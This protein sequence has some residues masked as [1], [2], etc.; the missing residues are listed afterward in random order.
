MPRLCHRSA[1]GSLDLLE[2]EAVLE[3]VALNLLAEPLWLRGLHLAE[4]AEGR[5]WQLYLDGQRLQ[6]GRDNSHLAP[7]DLVATRIS[8]EDLA[9]WLAAELQHPARNAAVD[10]APAHLRAFTLAAV[11][12]LVHDQGMPPAQLA[13]QQYPLVQRLA[14]RIAELRDQAGRSAFQQLVLDGG[15]TLEAGPEHVFRFD[16]AVYPVPGHQRYRGKFQ[17]S[18]HFYPVLACLDDGGEEWRCAMALDEQ[19]AVRHWVRNLDSDPVAGF[20]LPTSGG[21]FYPDFVAEL[22]DGRVLVA[23]YMGA[24]IRYMPKELEKAQVGRLWAQRSGGRAVF[25][26]VYLQEQGMGMAQQIAAAL[27]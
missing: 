20:W 27:G 7:L 18:K 26:M 16:P 23:E 5:G 6:V 3:T 10:V 19:P 9:R 2:R 21:R 13:R 11:H 22:V 15:W 25:A 14:L 4:Q 12:H 8:A 24:Q 17:F 1:Q